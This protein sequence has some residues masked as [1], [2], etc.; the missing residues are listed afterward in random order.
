MFVTTTDGVELWWEAEGTG[1]T[2]LLIPGRGDTT[3]LFPGEFADALMA[4]GLSVLR[5]DPRD[6]GLS[7]PGGGTYTVATLA[8]DAVAVLDAAA[9]E[10]ATWSASRWPDWSWLTS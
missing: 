3:D 9:V 2:V 4:G 5:W 10:V 1:P 7:G 8:T 6:T